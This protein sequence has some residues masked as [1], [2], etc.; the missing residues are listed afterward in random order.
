MAAEGEAESESGRGARHVEEHSGRPS[1]F[2]RQTHGYSDSRGTHKGVR[3]C[4]CALP[5][6]VQQQS[7]SLSSV[8]AAGVGRVLRVFGASVDRGKQGPLSSSEEECLWPVVAAP[9]WPRC[10][11]TLG[12]NWTPRGAFVGGIGVFVGAQAPMLICRQVP[13]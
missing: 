4:S 3:G 9:S 13:G 5:L 1:S 8:G 10:E 11:D 7:E 6:S 2:L 12:F